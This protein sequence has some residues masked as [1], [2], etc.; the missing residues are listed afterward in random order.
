MRRFRMPVYLLENQSSKK[1]P[2]KRGAETVLLIDPPLHPN[3]THDKRLP[4]PDTLLHMKA[5]WVSPHSCPRDSVSMHIGVLS[6]HCM[7]RVLEDGACCKDKFCKYSLCMWLS[8]KTW[9][10]MLP[11]SEYLSINCCISQ[12]SYE[13]GWPAVWSVC[14]HAWRWMYVYVHYVQQIYAFLGNQIQELIEVQDAVKDFSSLTYTHIA[15]F[16]W[17]LGTLHRFRFLSLKLSLTITTTCLP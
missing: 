16:P 2:E 8:V 10:L 3:V 11:V 4:R 6:T 1:P 14:K 7:Y 15:V 5:A 17:L 9:R 12:D 13:R